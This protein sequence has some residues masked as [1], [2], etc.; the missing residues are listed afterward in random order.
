[1]SSAPAGWYKDPMIPGAPRY[2]TGEAWLAPG[3]RPEAVAPESSQQ[4]GEFTPA[5]PAPPSPEDGPTPVANHVNPAA[6]AEPDAYRA[7]PGDRGAA[8]EHEVE[9]DVVG[10]PRR[11]EATTTSP[12]SLPP[13]PPATGQ[14]STPTVPAPSGYPTQQVF[15]APPYATQSYDAQPPYPPQPDAFQPTPWGSPPPATHRILGMT[16]LAAVLSVVALI[17]LAG[18]GW[19]TYSALTKG[20]DSRSIAGTASPSPSP[21]I[22]DATVRPTDTATVTPALG[23]LT[24]SPSGRFTYVVDPT[25]IYDS[26]SVAVAVASPAPGETPV[27]AWWSLDPSIE[28]TSAWIAVSEYDLPGSSLEEAHQQAVDTL[29]TDAEVTT[30]TSAPVDFTN[31]VHAV[32]TT[33]DVTVSGTA[34]TAIVYSFGSEGHYLTIFGLGAEPSEV[35]RSMDYITSGVTVS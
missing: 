30:R 35:S 14:L 16:P 28:P 29:V 27:A 26:N 5:A 8:G 3:E 18:G 2:W 22:S 21:E 24:T 34:M 19:F 9:W 25:W 15:T 33:V 7:T 23:G 17:V 31:G 12:S 1:M 4:A 11:P 10:V 20:S 6:M 13:W 32:T